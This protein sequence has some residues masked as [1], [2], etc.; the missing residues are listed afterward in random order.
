MNTYMSSSATLPHQ[1]ILTE[2]EHIVPK[3]EKEVAQKKKMSQK[4]LKK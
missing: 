4:K 3:S 2:K 1:V